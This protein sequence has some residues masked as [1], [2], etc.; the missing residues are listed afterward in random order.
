M[1]PCVLSWRCDTLSPIV[2]VR[3]ALDRMLWR[4]RARL[5]HAVLCDVRVD[6]SSRTLDHKRIYITI[7]SYGSE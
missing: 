7:N 6:Y 4:H 1:V 5:L 3:M 2:A